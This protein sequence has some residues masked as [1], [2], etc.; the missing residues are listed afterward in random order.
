MD[1]A[2]LRSAED[3]L[4][5]FSVNPANGLD[6]KAVQK[7]REKFGPNCKCLKKV[8]ASDIQC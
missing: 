8:A 6:A 4:A 5:G 2:F 7:N 1:D 3:C